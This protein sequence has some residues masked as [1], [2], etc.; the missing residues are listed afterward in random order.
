[1]RSREP[2]VAW[3][4]EDVRPKKQK[5]SQSISECTGNKDVFP[6]QFSEME[7][8]NY[9]YYYYLDFSHELIHIRFLKPLDEERVLQI[10]INGIHFI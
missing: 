7:T 8:Y 9:Y 5:R 2:Q 3:A 10:L 4:L 1:M 6:E